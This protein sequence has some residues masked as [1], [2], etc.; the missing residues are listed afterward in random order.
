MSVFSTL[1]LGKPQDKTSM[2][3][4]E[5]LRNQIGLLQQSLQ[6]AHQ[7]IM[8]AR[9][10]N[11]NTRNLATH[12]ATSAQAAAQ[13][14]G[15][16]SPKL[17][18]HFREYLQEDGQNTALW[19]ASFRQEVDRYGLLAYLDVPGYE[20]ESPM[21]QQVRSMLLQSMEAGVRLQ[22]EGA[23]ALANMPGWK[24]PPARAIRATPRRLWAFT[25]GVTMRTRPV[26]CPT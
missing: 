24:P 16:P 1:T 5:Y 6:E 18:S 8:E 10:E 14:A 23:M 2:A 11:A 19:N 4:M 21:I 25:S 13:T 20:T 9:Q 7:A 15:R 22:L 3:D 12:A 26:V 17:S